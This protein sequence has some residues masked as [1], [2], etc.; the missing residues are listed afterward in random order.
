LRVGA[1]KLRFNGAREVSSE[2][3]RVKARFG[4][5]F[6]MVDFIKAGPELWNEGVKLQSIVKI[7]I[8]SPEI[9]G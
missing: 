6:G 1:E 4:R 2:P 3:L 5:V 8:G 7:I 9:F